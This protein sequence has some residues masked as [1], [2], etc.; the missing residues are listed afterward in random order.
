MAV[1]GE[2]GSIEWERRLETGGGVAHGLLPWQWA[3]RRPAERNL[4][5]FSSGSDIKIPLPS[6]PLPLPHAR[7]EV[8][9]SKRIIVA[10]LQ[11]LLFAWT[12]TR[13]IMLSHGAHLYSHCCNL[14][15]GDPGLLGGTR[16]AAV[17]NVLTR[18]PLHNVAWW[19]CGWDLWRWKID[20]DVGEM[21]DNYS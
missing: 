14:C 19:A 1:G 3:P 18:I 13:E 17:K 16:F 10:I 11:D 5:G 7:R 15:S 8:G 20:A 4:A 21:K 9:L 6:L 12:L 2:Q